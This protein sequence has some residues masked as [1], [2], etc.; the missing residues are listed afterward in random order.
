MTP[1]AANRT[2]GLALA[3][4]VLIADQWLKHYVTRTLG[5]DLDGEQ[6]KLLPFFDLTRTSNFG[7][8][9]GMFTAHSMEMRW[10]LIAMT[11]GIAAA[12][13]VWQRRALPGCG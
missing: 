6:I 8:S 13:L 9:L 2:K 12:V 4:L 1:A 11:A 5:L 10:G 3:A 7:V